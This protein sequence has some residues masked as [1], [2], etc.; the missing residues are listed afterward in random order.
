MC[1][2]ILD[3]L[4]RTGINPPCR[5]ELAPTLRA[6]TALQ[7]LIDRHEVIPL[8]ADI[9]LRITHYES[10]KQ[11][12][13]TYLESHPH[14]PIPELKSHLQTTRRIMIPLLESLDRQGLTRRHGNQHE[15]LTRRHASADPSPQ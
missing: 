7:H 3:T 4:N 13:L 15:L 1:R 11:Q 5:S 2:S 8:N 10:A 9:I 14:A 12:I 6:R